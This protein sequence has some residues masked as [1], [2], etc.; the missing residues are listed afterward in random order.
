MNSESWA[1]FRTFRGFHIR[2]KWN[3][4]NVLQY[5]HQWWTHGVILWGAIQNTWKLSGPKVCDQCFSVFWF[6]DWTIIFGR[7]LTFITIV[8]FSF[9]L[10][11]N[12]TSEFSKLAK[13][14][15]RSSR[16][17]FDPPRLVWDSPKLLKKFIYNSST[18]TGSQFIIFFWTTTYLT[19]EIQLQQTALGFRYFQVA[20]GFGSTIGC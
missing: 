6:L 17:L 13:A 4:W 20:T 2:L 16:R 15:Q 11:E 12:G 3:T 1:Y 19:A 7:F 9:C 5:A 10:L 14:L 8:L 18:R